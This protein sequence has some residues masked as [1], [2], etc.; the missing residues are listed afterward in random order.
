MPLPTLNTSRLTL[1]PLTPDDAEGIFKA[2]SD[3]EAMRFIPYLPHKTVEETRK[4][5]Q[6][7]INNGTQYWG[8]RLQGSDEVIGK[9]GF[10]GNTRVP[11]MGY[12]LQRAHWGKG[13]VTE[14]MR[15]AITHGFNKKQLDRIE[16]WI[17][18]RNIG[19]RK[20]AEKLGF[21]ITGRVH[22]R[23]H[24][25]E[26]YH[27][28]YT[29]GLYATQWKDAIA[30]KVT[31]PPMFYSI[32]P[33]LVVHDVRAT[34]AFYRDR[35]G[36]HIDFLYGDPP[37]HAAV[38]RGD[39]ATEG[40]FIQLSAVSS[41]TEIHPQGWLYIMVHEEIDR[42]YQS[43]VAQGIEVENPPQTQ[44]WGMREFQIKDCN[45]YRLRFG[46]IAGR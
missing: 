23:F 46:T 21:H 32:Q 12:I 11:A 7:E 28:A 31:P 24:W 1:R 38:A 42:L 19:S 27:L 20:V 30:P 16:L 29:Y 5:I 9:V 3:P 22:S 15:P 45:G 18:E 40:A 33:V 13:L 10:L 37:T 8:I 39:W 26:K 25:E 41:D 43:F 2:Y 44:P 35:L 6:R 36:F 14:A 4:D 34:T 17:D